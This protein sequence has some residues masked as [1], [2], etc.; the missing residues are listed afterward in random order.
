MDYNSLGEVELDRERVLAREQLAHDIDLLVEKVSPSA[1]V[2]RRKRRMSRAWRR[3]KAEMGEQVGSRMHSMGSSMQ[4]MGSQVGEKFQSAKGRSRQM[5]LA[6]GAA[7]F[8]LGWGL[9][10]LIPMSRTEGQALSQV[11]QTVGEKAAPAVEQ[12]KTA[13]KEST[14]E[15]IAHR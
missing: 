6:T 9:S 7:A 15:A 4:G 2:E 12:A 14:Q 5:P 13:V 3:G 11:S 10:R 8:F 1:I